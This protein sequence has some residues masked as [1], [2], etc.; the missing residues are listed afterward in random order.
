MFL[1]NKLIFNNSNNSNNNNKMIFNKLFKI[2]IKILI[3][4]NKNK[5]QKV[6]LKI[7]NKQIKKKFQKWINYYNKKIK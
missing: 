5:Y 2:K 7:Q 6:L 4:N 3:I 1:Q